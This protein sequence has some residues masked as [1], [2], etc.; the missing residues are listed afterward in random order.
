[1]D[2]QF[3]QSD[4]IS[5]KQLEAWLCLFESSADARFYHHPHWHQCIAEHLCPRD[6][7]LGFFSD[8]DQLQMVLPLC[9]S[10]GERRRAHPL[11]DHLSLND[12]LI[13]PTLSSNADRLLTAIDITLDKLGDTWWDWRISNVPHHGALMQALTSKHSSLNEAEISTASLQSGHNHKTQ[14]W[15]LKRTRQSASFNCTTDERPPHGKLRRNLRRLRKQMDEHGTIR[16][17]RAVEPSQ[18][19]NAY[20]QFLTVE[21]SGWKGTGSEATAI[22]ANPELEQFY[23]SLLNPTAR[24]LSP[25]IN[26]LWCDDQCTAVQFG[27]RTGTC[28]SLL[29]IGY[30][31]AFARFSPGYLLLEAILGDTAERNINT[32]SLVTSPLWADRWHPNTVP[33]WQV[34]HYNQSAFGTA[35]HQL[36]RLKQ[37]AK[38]RL[39]HAA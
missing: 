23:Q 38:T 6:V 27:L 20:Q 10:S 25:E 2:V 35:L 11:H 34:N 5:P 9:R 36:D 14:N 19:E 26:L 18:L 31:E 39:R 32:L 12:L 4:A 16:I 8:N 21:A 24:G 1:M 28:L 37:I 7:Q 15:L 17:E 3:V 30:N 33:V 13:H 29:K 22:S